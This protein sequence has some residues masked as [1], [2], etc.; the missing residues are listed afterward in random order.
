MGL[1]NR[2]FGFLLAPLLGLV[3]AVSVS[4]EVEPLLLPLA[5]LE[6]AV[7]ALEGQLQQLQA[8]IG[9]IESTLEEQQQLFKKQKQILEELAKKSSEQKQLSDE[10][11]EQRILAKLGP[12]VRVHTSQNV[13]IKVFELK[14][15]GYRGYI[16]KV[17][18]FNPAALRVVLAKDTWGETETT[19]SAVARTGAILG[20]NGGGFYRSSRSGREYV[21]PLGNTV[22]DGKLLQ[23]FSPSRDGLFFAGIDTRGRLIGGLFTEKKQLLELKPWQ[24]VSFV[25]MLLKDRKPLPIPKEWQRQRHPRT[26]IGEY[27]NGDLVLI[28]VDGRQANWSQGVTLEELQIKLLDLGVV[29]AYNL[30]G[31]GSS[32]FVFDGE[33][34]NRP[35]DGRERPVATNIVIMP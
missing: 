10:I 24:G 22:I 21:V 20:V 15:M 2:F 26:I 34:L 19:S 4:L 31:G 32:T 12:P 11:Y 35:S 25:P 3:L 27:A 23:P 9:F 1:V 6:S 18:L 13:E 16:A 14:E 29:E 17:K 5:E 28:V 8:G 7:M 30:D 33:V